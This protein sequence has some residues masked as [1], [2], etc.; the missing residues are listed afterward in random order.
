M[1]SRSRPRTC[2]FKQLSS[3][4]FFAR[5]AFMTGWRGYLRGS[6]L[7]A[8]GLPD[9]KS[10]HSDMHQIVRRPCAQLAALSCT[11]KVS[12]PHAAQAYADLQ[13][14][15]SSDPSA[16]TLCERANHPL[17]SARSV[18]ESSLIT[19]SLL[20]MTDHSQDRMYVPSACTV[21]S[22]HHP[23]HGWK[24]ASLRC[25]QFATA[26]ASNFSQATQVCAHS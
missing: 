24:S 8:D 17:G 22:G 15:T 13:P 1:T 21:H 3:R 12:P 2:S 11:C 10:F 5:H 23:C 4:A 20:D 19:Q 9:I 18:T 7:L 26:L 25:L 16:F 6:E 14:C